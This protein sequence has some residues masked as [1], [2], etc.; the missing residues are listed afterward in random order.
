MQPVLKRQRNG[1]N[2][3][4]VSYGI[5]NTEK[6][7]QE[8]EN[9]SFINASNAGKNINQKILQI[10]NSVRTIA[11]RNTEELQDL[12]MKQEY[13]KNAAQNLLS[14]NIQEPD[15][16][17]SHVLENITEESGNKENVYDMQIE[18]IHEYFANGILVHNSIDASRYVI[19]TEVIGKNRRKIN[20][21]QLSELLP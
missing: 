15:F 17:A 1:I 6:K 9:I 14:I 16:A 2:L 8:K 18:C 13:V 3:K 20:I 11:N 4:T 5:V 12:T 21:N 7:L 19:L 10:Q